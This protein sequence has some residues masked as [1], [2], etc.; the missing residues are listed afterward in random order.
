MRTIIGWPRNRDWKTVSTAKL[1]SH[2][3]DSVMQGNTNAQSKATE[4]I[5]IVNSGENLIGFIK[6]LFFSQFK[7]F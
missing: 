7:N 2:S 1:K 3:Q 6:Q 4:T 5:M